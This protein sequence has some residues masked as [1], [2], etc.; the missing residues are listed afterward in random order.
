MSVCYIVCVCVYYVKWFWRCF[1]HISCRFVFVC[2]CVPKRTVTI[3]IRLTTKLC[4]IGQFDVYASLVV[5]SERTRDVERMEY[6]MCSHYIGLCLCVFV[7]YAWWDQRITCTWSFHIINK[8]FKAFPHAHSNPP[9]TQTHNHKAHTFIHQTAA[10][11]IIINYPL[12]FLFFCVLDS[13]AY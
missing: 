2:M 12:L 9:Y 13:R 6:S 4:V 3:T 11:T 5:F 8:H 10:A 1:S 7:L